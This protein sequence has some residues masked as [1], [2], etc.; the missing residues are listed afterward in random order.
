MSTLAN[1]PSL[2]F[3]DCWTLHLQTAS[4]GQNVSERGLSRSRRTFF[5]CYVTFL[6][7][8]QGSPSCSNDVEGGSAR[9]N[10]TPIRSTQPLQTCI[11]EKLAAQLD[12]H[13]I[14]D[15]PVQW[16]RVF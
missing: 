11:G 2:T 7:G 3:G 8:C 4:T 16:V 6:Q 14:P 15:D 13:N 12:N 1:M 10:A 5:I 9:Q